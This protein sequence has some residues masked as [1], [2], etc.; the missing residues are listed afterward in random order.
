[1]SVIQAIKNCE[2]AFKEQ[3]LDPPRTILITRETAAKLVRELDD[4][5]FTPSENYLVED[6][7][8]IGAV[9]VRW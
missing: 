4:W 2:H 1:M 5:Q 3:N 8:R 9:I 6:T 7:V